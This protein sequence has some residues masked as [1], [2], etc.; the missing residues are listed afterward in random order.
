MAHMLIDTS[1]NSKPLLSNQFSA[2]PTVPHKTRSLPTN[3]TLRLTLNQ[4]QPRD[5]PSHHQLPRPYPRLRKFTIPDKMCVIKVYMFPF[6]GCETRI[7]FQETLH[8][9]CGDAT[10]NYPSTRCPT[11]Q[12]YRL[13]WEMHGDRSQTDPMYRPP[14]E[15]ERNQIHGRLA[16][17]RPDIIQSYHTVVDGHERGLPQLNTVGVY[18]SFSPDAFTFDSARPIIMATWPVL[19]RLQATTIQYATIPQIIPVRNGHAPFHHV[20]HAL[21]TVRA[22]YISIP[23]QVVRH[24]ESGAVEHYSTVWT[25][26][27]SLPPGQECIPRNHVLFNVLPFGVQEVIRLAGADYVLV[28]I[29][30]IENNI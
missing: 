3:E 7:A 2:N 1:T 22:V 21:P 14:C 15:M 29:H 27:L 25:R 6:C 30:E 16:M 26:Q 12:T 9:T 5:P 19:N 11:R 18:T 24:H 8:N 13:I 10:Q 17:L 28:A 20:D 4:N 23:A